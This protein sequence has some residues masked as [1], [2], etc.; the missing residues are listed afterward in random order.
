MPRPSWKWL[1]REYGLA[2][3][4]WTESSQILSQSFFKLAADLED[5]LLEDVLVCP[6][7]CKTFVGRLPDVIDRCDE[8]IYEEPLVAP[9]YAYVHLLERYR[10]FWS[11]LV[12]L[13]KGR[14]LPMAD[15]GIDVLDVGTGPAPGLYAVA[16]FYD[17]VGRYAETAH[18]PGLATGPPNLESV[19]SSKGMTRFVHA[20]S[21]WTRRAG[22]FRA[23]FSEF[24]GLVLP[25]QRQVDIEGQA[26]QIADEFDTSEQFARWWMRESE[27]WRYDVFRYN[28]VIFSNFLTQPNM[29][30]DLGVELESVFGSLRPGAVLVVV[31]GTGHHY[32]QVYAMVDS[33]ASQ[34]RTRRVDWV[35]DSLPSVYGDDTAQRIKQVYARVWT[36][37]EE[38][39]GDVSHV[40]ECLPQDLWDRHTPLAGPARFGLRVFRKGRY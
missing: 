13:T 4:A 8:D 22:P 27:P 25:R 40:C 39:C 9:A 28:L 33:I 14:V 23:T 5:Y 36:R 12:E 29:V 24:R 11:V 6:Q 15:D 3:L 21:E 17:A 34:T 32:P 37:L 26:R 7:A 30:D 16:D 2:L 18:V 31:G 1:L 35:A 20:F 19:E 38:C 10:R